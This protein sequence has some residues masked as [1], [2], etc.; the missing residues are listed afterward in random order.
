MEVRDS[1]I[2]SAERNVLVAKERIRQD[3]NL[4]P[5]EEVEER[6]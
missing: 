4:A 3:F 5:T 6:S 2:D 1:A